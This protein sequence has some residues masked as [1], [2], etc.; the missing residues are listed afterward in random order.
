MVWKITIGLRKNHMIL[1]GKT[2]KT[3]KTYDFDRNPIE[4]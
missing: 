3:D 4:F 2:D 1:I